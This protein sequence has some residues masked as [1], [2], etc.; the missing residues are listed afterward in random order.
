MISKIMNIKFKWI[1][2]A[3]P[4]YILRIARRQAV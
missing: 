2:M 4:S 1:L 3:K